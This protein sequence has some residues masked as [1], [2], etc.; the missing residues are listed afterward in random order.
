MITI[1]WRH[2]LIAVVGVPVAVLL[3]AWIGFFNVGASTG[4]WK[5]T[6]WFLH[7]AM[8][9]AVRTYSIGIEAPP[10]DDP[11]MLPPA[12]AHFAQGCA[13]CHGAPGQ[14]RSPVAM[15]MLPRPPDL[16][17][18]VDDWRDEE[19]FRIVKH[20]VRFTGM[21]AWPSQGR[22]DEV[23]AMVA[24]LRKLPGLDARSYRAL[25]FGE[26]GN[27]GT[28]RP[29]DFEAALAV[30]ARCHGFDGAGRSERVPIIAGQREAYMAE[31]LKAFAEEWRASGIMELAAVEA[32]RALW[33]DLARHYALQAAA[34]ASISS[35]GDGSEGDRERGGE[36]ARRGIP[37]EGVPAC[38]GCHERD[39]GNPTY[40]TISG[41]HAASI[42]AQLRRFAA[43]NRG[44]TPYQGLM[45]K[46][47]EGLSEEDMRDLAA[48]FSSRPVDS[49]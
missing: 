15:S 34:P 47:A 26:A 22:D 1:G 37:A 45:A 17:G 20:G 4:H 42:E 31:S 13:I 35:E 18:V 19:L 3:A 46:V 10:L 5:I 30:C 24:F 40:P 48:Y 2:I 43:G 38:F 39:G 7:F 11:A 33:R 16:S 25:A 8:R 6:E 12:A 23:W 29:G 28:G 27:S 49:R 41:Q 44:G 21:P 14:P 36:I 9:A 32:D